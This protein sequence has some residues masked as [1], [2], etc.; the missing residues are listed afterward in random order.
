M[1]KVDTSGGISRLSRNLGDEG[2]I[3]I[4]DLV[5]RTDFIGFMT[6]NLAHPTSFHSRIIEWR[7]NAL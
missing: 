7:H 6:L 5:N 4:L 2:L 1:D 3:L